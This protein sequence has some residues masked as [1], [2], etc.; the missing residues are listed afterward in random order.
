MEQVEALGGV[1]EGEAEV[2]LVFAEALDA[3]GARAAA[4]AAIAA[5]R[6]RLL[7]RAARITGDTWRRSFLE[8]VPEH[9]RTIELARA[10]LVA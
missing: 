8:N 5:A 6:V 4:I 2:R 3:S 7:E 1:D 9:G 10:W